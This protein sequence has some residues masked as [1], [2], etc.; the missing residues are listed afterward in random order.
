ANKNDEDA[1][2]NQATKHAEKE[3]PA[4]Q[5]Q[6][7]APAS[8]DRIK[9]VPRKTMLKRERFELAP[10]ASLSLNDAYYQHLAFSGSAVFYPHDSFG[11]GVGADW[12]YGHIKDH[13]LDTVRTSLTSVVAVLEQPWLFAH[14]DAYWI[15][16]YG[17]L[18]LFD[19]TIVHF[20]LYTITGI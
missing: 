5:K 8:L 20:D 18:S 17:K 10:F 19:K 13:T 6:E 9:A 12:L 15:P 3:T 7:I 2:V 14:V 4:T 16:I 1:D 11:I